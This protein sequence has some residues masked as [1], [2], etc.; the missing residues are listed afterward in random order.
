MD[1][2]IALS[3]RPE[4]PVTPGV[5]PVLDRGTLILE[6]L[7]PLAGPTV[8]LDYRRTE[9]WPR[10][11]SVFADPAGG[12]VV[13]HRQGAALVR[14]S[15]AGP[16][17]PD[18][19]VAR[20]I[21]TWDARARAWALRFELPDTGGAVETRGS[22]P[23]PFRRDDLAAACAGRGDV[24]RHPALL[25][26]GV[27]EGGALPDRTPWVGLRTP[28]AT[29]AGLRLAGTLRPGDLVLTADGGAQPIRQARRMEMPS[30]GSY[31]PV[32]LRAPYFCPAADLLVSAD[33]LVALRGAEVEYLFG[34]EEVLAEARL[35]VDGRSALP[36]TRRA[37]AA[38]VA[39]ELPAPD[40]ILSAGLAFAV[41]GPSGGAPA[42]RRLL[43]YEAAPLLALLGRDRAGRAA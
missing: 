7:M 4:P 31:T 8:L 17:P 43:G 16:L 26:Y 36:D 33:Q 38:C 40:L 39:L 37:L 23:I 5:Q 19:G 22:G 14:H 15:L 11:L 21:L 3:D 12:V 27:T 24:R 32:L 10:V 20:I 2:W 28:I 42:R 41:T 30:R 29:P 9:D 13:L 1:Q 25:W 35:L 34:E 18:R 6:F